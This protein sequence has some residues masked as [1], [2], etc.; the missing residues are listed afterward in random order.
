MEINALWFD[1]A[2]GESSNEPP[3]LRRQKSLAQQA[4][5]RKERRL[6]EI[7]HK[8]SKRRME[9]MSLFVPLLSAQ[10]FFQSRAPKRAIVGSNRAGKSLHATYE[11]VLAL[12]GNDPYGKYPKT[13][14]AQF[15]GMDSD[16]LADPMLSKMIRPGE[17]KIIRDEQ[18]NLWRAVRPDPNNPLRLDPYDDAYRE[19][20]KDAPPLLP[21]RYIKEIVWAYR[22]KGVPRILRTPGWDALWRSSEGD[23]SQG[24]KINL[25]WIDEQ[26]ENEDFYSE[27]IRGLTDYNGSLIWSATPQN[28]NP[29]LIDLYERNKKGDSN[30]A[31]FTLLIAN[32]PYVSEEGKREFYES[33]P[34]E[35]RQV[36][37]YGEPA[38]YGMAIYGYQPMSLHGCEPFKIP[39]NWTHYAVIDP[40]GGGGSSHVGNV[41][42]AVDPDEK[43]V[44]VYDAFD[45]QH[46]DA[47]KLAE[48]L[49]KKEPKNG[50][51]AIIIDQ[52]AGQQCPFASSRTVAQQY[53]D[54]LQ[55]AGVVP[56]TLGPM[57]GFIRGTKDVQ[58]RT[59]AL[60]SWLTVRDGGVGAGTARLQVMRNISQRLDRQLALARYEDNGKRCKKY[61]E[62][63]LVC[64]EYAAG[65][66]PHYMERTG[67]P[68]SSRPSPV[69]E[70]LKKLDA[71]NNPKV[72]TF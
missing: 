22:N 2:T 51:E 36:R 23:A 50:Y 39:D 46:T 70:Y 31:V 20:W 67:P 56:H 69:L 9:G 61:P 33:L 48:T 41:H 47:D 18:T 34:E 8:L 17:F 16:H 52:Q 30:V 53:W 1:P 42:L 27:L 12:T 72:R 55:R 63:L 11:I 35:E 49:R 4:R 57:H 29:Q 60:K 64:L 14:Q 5:Q 28:R 62:D 45:M 6:L 7:V 43:H 19:K 13:G 40:G 54:A 38:I 24:R 15:I 44:W 71:K 59:E 65:Y 37:W 66:N 3:A 21:S 25:G 58:A 68:A 26:I 10:G 32:N